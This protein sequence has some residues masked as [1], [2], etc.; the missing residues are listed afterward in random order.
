MMY[1][2]STSARKPPIA[3]IEIQPTGPAAAIEST[4]L[5]S[6][7]NNRLGLPSASGYDA[8]SIR[9]SIL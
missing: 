7:A 9:T 2:T 3:T 4:T 1:T 5:S 6:K 8:K